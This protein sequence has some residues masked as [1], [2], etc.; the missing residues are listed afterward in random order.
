MRMKRFIKLINFDQTNTTE[1][2]SKT[3]A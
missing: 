1:F 3:A 2:A